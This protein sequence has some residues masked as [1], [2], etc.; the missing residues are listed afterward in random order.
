MK[1]RCLTY[2]SISRAVHN[3]QVGD[4]VECQPDAMMTWF[5]GTVVNIDLLQA[6]YEVA[7][8]SVRIGTV[9]FVVGAGRQPFARLA[10]HRL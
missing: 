5:R 8:E 9:C 2:V 6:L 10:R 3:F 7:L 1:K 4:M